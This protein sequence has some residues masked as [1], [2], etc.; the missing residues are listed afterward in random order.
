[1]S[2]IES[3]L[4]LW[5]RSRVWLANERAGFL[6]RRAREAQ[7]QEGQL[8]PV[9][10]T[11][12]RMMSLTEGAPVEKARPCCVG[13]KALEADNGSAFEQLGCAVTLLNSPGWLQLGLDRVD[14]SRA[15]DDENPHLRGETVNGE[16]GN[17]INFDAC[18]FGAR[19]T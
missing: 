6:T 15:A 12:D 17:F 8:P 16:T 11:Y 4:E 10:M 1:M 13:W 3:L 2:T 18:I 7:P 5:L 14:N 9:M 19:E